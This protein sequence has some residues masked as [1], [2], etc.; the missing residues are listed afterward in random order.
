[1]LVFYFVLKYGVI[2]RD[3]DINVHLVAFLVLNAYS[4]VIVYQRFGGICYFHFQCRSE[5]PTRLYSVI[6]Q[7]TTI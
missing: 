6:T 1:M 4:L 5:A 3:R 7:K 2:F